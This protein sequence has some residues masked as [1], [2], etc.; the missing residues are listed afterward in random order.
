MKNNDQHDKDN[1]HD[2]NDALE[3]THEHDES[4]EHAA[5]DE[6]DQMHGPEQK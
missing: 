6:H 2:G 1:N 5:N 3:Q 4:E